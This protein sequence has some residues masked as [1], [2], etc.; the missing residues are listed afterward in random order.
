MTSEDPW[1]DPLTDG[2]PMLDF[3]AITAMIHGLQKSPTEH[4]SLSIKNRMIGSHS[5]KELR[6]LSALATLFVRHNE[7]SFSGNQ[8][9]RG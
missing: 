4:Q 1:E 2:D 5:L 7:V 8:T 3:R 6:L 9:S